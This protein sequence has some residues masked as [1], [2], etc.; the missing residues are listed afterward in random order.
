MTDEERDVILKAVSWA[1]WGKAI[2]EKSEK[3]CGGPSTDLLR[4]VETMQRVANSEFKGWDWVVDQVVLPAT[5]PGA[6]VVRGPE[7]A[8]SGF[9]FKRL[10]RYESREVAEFVAKALNPPEQS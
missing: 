2:V 3:Y 6:Y 10:G 8:W 1:R 5:V 7:E 4:A 9:K